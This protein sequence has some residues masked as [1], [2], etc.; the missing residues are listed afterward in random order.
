MTKLT[1]ERKNELIELVNKYCEQHIDYIESHKDSGE[2]YSHLPCEGGFGYGDGENRLKEY[3][4]KHGLEFT[5][6]LVDFVLDN[7][8][9]ESAHVFKNVDSGNDFYIAGYPIGE[10]EIC[11]NHLIDSGQISYSELMQIENECNVYIAGTALAYAVS[12]YAW[13]AMISLETIKTHLNDKG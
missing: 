3:C 5:D 6:S 9:M 2:S 11:L 8:T 13:N 7:F 1:E 4:V 12:D 10:I